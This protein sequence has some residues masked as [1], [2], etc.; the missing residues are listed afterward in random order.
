MAATL[1]AAARRSSASLTSLLLK[2][3]AS[4][5]KVGVIG[6]G[7]IGRVHLETLAGVPGVQPVILSDVV[8]PVLKEVT[9]QYG[10]PNYTL[11]GDEVIN[12]P[13][14][15]AVWICSPSQFHADQ[16]KKCAKAG[17][18]V[19]CEKP[20]A[21]DLNGTIEAIKV[22][23]EAGI[24]LMTAFQ[25]RFDP[26]FARL[27][28]AIAEGSVGEPISAI[29]QSRD[30][31]PPPFSYVKGGGGLFKDMAIHDLDIARWLMGAR[32]KNDVVQVYA[33]GHCFIDPEIKQL[34]KSNPSEAI[35]TAFIQLT[36]EN[37]GNVTINVCRRATYGYDQRVEF[38]GK[39]G[40]LMHD[41]LYPNNVHLW[42]GQSTG[43]IDLPHNFFMSRYAEAYKNETIAFCQTLQ[44][45]KAPS[46]SGHDGK[47]ALVLAMACDKS[48]KEKRPVK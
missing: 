13:D 45:G 35:D 31:S 6:A 30:P 21:T 28:K 4:T 20:I 9:A 15:Q 10:V 36:F 34:E 5:L 33:T 26:S 24:K 37:G 38:F 16:I 27:H 25:R 8:E 29:L 46:P 12:H 14:V 48:F 40:T 44:E 18:H 39:E 23:D 47:M 42:N 1:T 22:A 41:N 43:R 17:K 19:F 32:G 2:R 7:R 3:H 11:D